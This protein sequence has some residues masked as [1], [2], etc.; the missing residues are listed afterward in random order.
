[1][2][3]SESVFVGIRG[4]R[5]VAVGPVTFVGAV[6]GA[7]VVLLTG[8][9]AVVLVRAGLDVAAVVFRH[10]QKREGRGGGAD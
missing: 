4:P 9:G 6:G 1:M 10:L 3:S 8:G 2:I 5:Q 7:A